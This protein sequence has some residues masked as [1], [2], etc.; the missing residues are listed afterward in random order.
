MSS[1]NI[2]WFLKML[3]PN[4]IFNT[5]KMLGPKKIAGPKKI[6]LKKFSPKKCWVNEMD[7]ILVKFKNLGS[8][9]NVRPSL[10]KIG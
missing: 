9:K 8:K 2:S 3:C 4:K 1:E 7:P 10:V 6:E 5:N